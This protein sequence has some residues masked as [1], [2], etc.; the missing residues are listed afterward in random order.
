MYLFLNIIV[1]LQ[2]L[3]VLFWRIPALVTVHHRHP[4][5]S[6][7]LGTSLDNFAIDIMHTLHLGVWLAWNHRALWALLRANVYNTRT[8]RQADDMLV[9]L[10][11]LMQRLHDWYPIY[12][13]TLSPDRVKGLTKIQRITPSMCNSES[14]VK[15]NIKAAESRH[16]LPFLLKELNFFASGMGDIDVQAR[17]DSGEAL[18]QYM[19]VLQSES[20][21]VSADGYKA[22]L[23][24]CHT[25]VQLCPRA[26][27]HL[28]PKHHLFKHMT[29]RIARNGNPR[30]YSTYFDEGLNKVLVGIASSCY[31]HTF[32][33]RLFAKFRWVQ[34]P[35]KNRGKT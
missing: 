13:K 21:V 35:C 29:R 24:C 20:R 18:E 11:S 22:L 17:I 7:E 9:S 27:I 34:K 10:G 6:D 32:E 23:D 8:T 28:L 16:L 30:Y 3:L 14:D 1:P 33:R 31:R 12:A 5:L 4:L 15:L 19:Q 26:G 25:H 2:G